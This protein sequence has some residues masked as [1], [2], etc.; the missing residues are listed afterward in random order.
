MYTKKN[1]AIIKTLFEHVFL[2]H[3]CYY[4]WN[5]K[6]KNVIRI[7]KSLN[8]TGERTNGLVDK[9]S[10]RAVYPGTVAHIESD[11]M[12]FCTAFL[13]DSLHFNS[14][15]HIFLWRFAQHTTHRWRDQK[16][17]LGYIENRDSSKDIRE[18]KYKIDSCTVS[19]RKLLDPYEIASPRLLFKC[20]KLM[21][22][23]TLYSIDSSLK[24]SLLL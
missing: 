1:T 3:S 15:I 5:L 11:Q 18:K 23:L 13:K 19:I 10:V 14:H 20:F 12:E 9:Y 6:N 7:W 24:Q 4:P 8:V 16:K 17:L 2:E 21:L 22:P